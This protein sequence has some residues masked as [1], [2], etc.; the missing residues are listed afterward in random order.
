MVGILVV[1]LMVVPVVL[2][3][4]W[5]LKPPKFE[6]LMTH[7]DGDLTYMTDADG[8]RI[9]GNRYTMT[10]HDGESVRCRVRRFPVLMD[11]VIEACK[12]SR[13]R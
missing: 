1:T 5:L 4:A 10:F 12:P 6:T 8:R 7:R 3:G 13:R 9:H 11:P 2:F